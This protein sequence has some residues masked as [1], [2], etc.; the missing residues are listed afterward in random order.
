MDASV[1]SVAVAT[2]RSN[3][4]AVSAATPTASVARVSVTQLAQPSPAAD[5]A[6]SA[7][8]RQ[9]QR[10]AAGETDEP[11]GAADPDRPRQHDQE[12]DRAGEPDQRT[13]LFAEI[14]QR[15]PAGPQRCSPSRASEGHYGARH[16]PV[17]REAV[18]QD[19]RRP[20]V[21]AL[22]RAQE[23]ALRP[24][25]VRRAGELRPR[26]RDPGTRGDTRPSAPASPCST[27][28]AESPGRDGFLTRE[29]GC[30]Y[31]GVDAS[32][33]AVAVA[34]ERAGGLPCRFVVAQVP[35]LPPGTFDVVLLLE[36]MLAFRDK[37]TLVEAVSRA[38]SP[39][40]RFAFTFEEGLPLTE[41]ERARMPGADTVWLTPL[42]EMHALLARA[43]LVVRRQEDWSRSHRA[44]AQSL[45]DAYAADAPA[46]ASRIGHRALDE[47][48]AAHRLW[49]EWLASGRVRKIAVVAERPP[50]SR[51]ASSRR[52]PTARDR[53]A[54]SSG[55]P[56]EARS[57]RR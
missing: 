15:P 17:C 36:T 9:V 44:V 21:E 57:A 54:G 4:A 14:G 52:L 39:G 7:R 53:G 40:G 11:A 28:A 23:A 5:R 56:A 3:E 32:A 18:S 24:R 42:D 8:E 13:E 10:Q 47:L 51:R 22:R 34:R 45:T 33:N 49:T 37:E 19:E 38:L 25:R 48:L 31:V 41:S 50:L 2:G 12:R 43:G 55:S 30:N 1:T 29:L 27:C 6:K 26:V 35:P 16:A 46:I 20:V